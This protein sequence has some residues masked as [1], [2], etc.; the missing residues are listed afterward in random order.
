MASGQLQM[1]KIVG[2]K[3]PTYKD[4]EKIEEGEFT[5]QINPENYAQ[6]FEIEYDED[7]APGTSDKLPKYNK[8]KPQ[9]LEFE[10][11]FDSTGAVP[12]TTDEQRTS[13]F[14]VLE[15][16]DQF[17]KVAF[18]MDGETHQPP[19]L[20]LSWGT[21]LFKCV[22]TGMTLTYKLFRPDGTPVRAVIKAKFQGLIEDALRVAKENKQSPDLTH[23]RVVQAGDTLPLMCETIYGD[24][25]YYLE[26]A[27]INKLINFRN[28]RIGQKIEFPPL[29]KV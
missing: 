9:V 8:T 5:V 11:V 3:K 2:Y 19:F 24:P 13:A 1:M 28:L 6:T 21:L 17:K 29:A 27:R 23:V 7:Q 26:V 15:T 25:K 16:I 22:L 12:G 4:S 14:G 20:I 10:F 18:S